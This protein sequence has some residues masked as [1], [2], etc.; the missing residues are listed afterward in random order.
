MNIS[1][2]PVDSWRHTQTQWP[3]VDTQQLKM[4]TNRQLDVHHMPKPYHCQYTVKEP[5][6]FVST[7]LQ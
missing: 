7:W 2:Q 1:L 3:G 6:L 5:L 4:S